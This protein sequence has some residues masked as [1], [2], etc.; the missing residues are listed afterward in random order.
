MHVYTKTSAHLRN[1]NASKTPT[2]YV[3]NVPIQNE[4]HRNFVQ[5]FFID[6][7]RE[8][9]VLVN[10]TK[11]RNQKKFWKRTIIIIKT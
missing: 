2:T 11:N 10:K 6:L 7:L 3:R 5:S 9:F 1:E 8:K 4:A